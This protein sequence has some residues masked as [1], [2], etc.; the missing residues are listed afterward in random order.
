MTACCASLAVVAALIFLAIPS[1]IHP[2]AWN[3]P[4]APALTGVLAP[5]NKLVTR[6]GTVYFSDS[7]TTLLQRQLH[8]A[9]RQDRPHPG[10]PGR[11][12]LTSSTA[13][14]STALQLSSAVWAVDAPGVILFSACQLRS[15]AAPPGPRGAATDGIRHARSGSIVKGAS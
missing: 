14:A 10:T 6:D 13:H 7:S 2:L 4:P 11:S 1:P 5:N 15:F 8:P 12:V 3:P 9:L